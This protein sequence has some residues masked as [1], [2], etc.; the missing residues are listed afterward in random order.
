MV[1]WFSSF[2]WF[3]FN[4]ADVASWRDWQSRLAPP[5]LLPFFAWPLRS[6]S[7]AG[8][9][10]CANATTSSFYRVSAEGND[11]QHDSAVALAVPSE[12]QLSQRDR[13][14]RYVSRKLNCCTTVWKSHVKRLV[15]DDWPWKSLKPWGHH[16][17]SFHSCEDVYCFF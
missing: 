1:L 13:A 14:T 16:N 11:A 10:L 6:R 12:A 4:L 3:V 7:T 17:W 15:I 9:G 2:E 5:L 8:H